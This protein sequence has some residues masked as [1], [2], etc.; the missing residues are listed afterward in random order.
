MSECTVCYWSKS[1][2]T[3]TFNKSNAIPSS[4]GGSNIALSDIRVYATK[5]SDE[6]LSDL[7]TVAI[8]VDNGNYIHAYSFNESDS[9]SIDSKGVLSNIEFI[10][11]NDI[12]KIYGSQ[13][14]SRE[15][16]E[17]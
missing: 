14:T 5:L 7:E 10:E 8:S 6:D 15:F 12:V 11:V 2:N 13:V 1:G 9:F 16:Y 17:I 3:W 4:L